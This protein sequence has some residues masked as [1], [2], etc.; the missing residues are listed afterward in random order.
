LSSLKFAIINGDQDLLRIIPV[1]TKVT[2]TIDF[3]ISTLGNEYA[4]NYWALGLQK[5]KYYRSHDEITYHSSVKTMGKLKPGIIHE[6]SQN[7]GC[8]TYQY[9]FPK[10]TDIQVNTE[11]P[12]PLLKLSIN[13]KSAKTYA[14]KNDHVIFNFD[15]ESKAPINTVELYV[16]SKH[17]DEKFIQKWASFDLLW[18]ISTIDYLV[19]GPELSP[20]FLKRLNNGPVILYEMDTSF[21]QFN[22]ISKFYFDENI[23]ENTISFYENFDYVS[24]LAS[25]R[26]QWIDELTK[27]PLSPLAPAFVFDLSRQQNQGYTKKEIAVWNKFFNDS[28]NKIDRLGILRTGFYIPQL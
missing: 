25:T 17:F 7:S 10:V 9:S 13:Q 2:T 5:P 1:P 20:Q 21:P 3:K 26:I 14:K 6:K 28:L 11:F 23:K 15:D 4:I 27:E 22:L 18:K 16:V 8:V 19:K 24:I 12:L